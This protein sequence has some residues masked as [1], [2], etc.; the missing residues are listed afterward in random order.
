MPLPKIVLWL[1]ASKQCSILLYVLNVCMYVCMYRCEF[2]VVFSSFD[3]DTTHWIWRF[4]MHSHTITK[5][6]VYAV[7]KKLFTQD[8]GVLVIRFFFCFSLSFSRSFVSFPLIRALV[9]VLWVGSAISSGHR[10][11]KNTPSGAKCLFS[12]SIY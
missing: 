11:L 9:Y 6:N 8:A 5:P 12:T 10:C 2:R 3:S 4:T 7:F 1:S